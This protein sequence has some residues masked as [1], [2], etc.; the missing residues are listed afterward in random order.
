MLCL[1]LTV[2]VVVQ[3]LSSPT[4]AAS[5]DNGAF[6][7]FAQRRLAELDDLLGKVAAVV[8]L[9]AFLEVKRFGLVALLPVPTV[10]DAFFAEP[11]LFGRAII[12]ASGSVFIVAS[13]SMFI[14]TS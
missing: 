3:T 4:V 12:V 11:L 13:W 6:V 2:V 8:E 14:V 5:L 9:F 10:E 1:V 7:L